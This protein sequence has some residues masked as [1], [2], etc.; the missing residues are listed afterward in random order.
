MKASNR[1]HKTMNG[2]FSELSK[3]GCFSYNGHYPKSVEAKLRSIHRQ[4]ESIIKKE[5]MDEDSA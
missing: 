4:L 1:L 2:Y 3:V 5:M